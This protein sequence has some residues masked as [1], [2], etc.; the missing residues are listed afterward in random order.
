MNNEC[1]ICLLSIN[2][3][4]LCTTSCNHTFCYNCLKQWLDKKKKTCPNCRKEIDYFKYN[5]ETNRLIYIPDTTISTNRTTNITLDE[6]NT[7]LGNNTII[8]RNLLILLKTL[9]LSSLLFLSS[10][11]Y[12]LIDGNL[13]Y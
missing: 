2:N 13:D 4:N 7:I 11:I 10:T 6:I 9:S 3:D 12:L 1:S 5:N 8:N